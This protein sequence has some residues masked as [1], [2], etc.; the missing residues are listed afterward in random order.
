MSSIEDVVVVAALI[1]AS[2]LPAVLAAGA[3]HLLKLLP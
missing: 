2:V 3:H 1:I